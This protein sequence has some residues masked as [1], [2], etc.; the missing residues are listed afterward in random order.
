VLAVVY[1][2]QEITYAELNKKANALA[3]KL[4]SI[5]VGPDDFVPI[6]AQRSAEMLIGLYAVLKAGGAYVPMDPDYPDERIRYMLEDCRPKAI[7]TY[8]AEMDVETDAKVLDLEDEKLYEGSTR[9]LSKVTGPDNLAYCI[10]TSGTT[11]RPKGVMIK[12]R[13][14]VNYVMAKKNTTMTYAYENHLTRFVSVTNMVF[15]IFV[16]EAIAT[17]LTGMTVYVAN[18]EQ[19]NDLAAFERLVADH[20][21]EILQTTPSRIKGLLAQNGN[22]TAFKSMKYVMLGGESVGSDVVK[23]LK[24]V[25]GAVIENVYGPS[26]TTVWST[27]MPIEKEYRNIPVGKPIANTQV[28]V[29]DGGSLCGIGVPGELCIAGDGVARGYLNQSELTAE[30]FVDNPF[31]EGRMYHTGDLAR[32]LPDGNVEYLGRM[33]DQVKVGGFRIE[34]GEIEAKLRE[35]SGVK[36]C[37]VVVREDARGEKVICAY[38]VGENE[39][40]IQEIRN[41]LGKSLPKYM[42]PSYMT[43][44]PQIPVNKNGKLDK[45]ALPEISQESSADYDAPINEQEVVLTDEIKGMLN[46]DT[47]SR[48]D[49]FFEIGGNSMKATILSSH[50]RERGYEISVREIMSL[51]IIADIA[52]RMILNSMEQQQ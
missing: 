14:V 24:E 2:D 35:I 51:G 19:Q 12:N 1:E 10:Y 48:N 16:T 11:G 50:L 32:W 45:K 27:C 46:L 25:T 22:T 42:I 13:N 40:G 17:M 8:K 30:K 52:Q 23:R 39:N 41:E 37:A 38:I 26:E 31:G 9:N 20:Q 44:I 34:L 7:L 3:R 18:R 5:G 21:I 4:R 28:Y 36:D 43:Y 15:D 6:L 29:V 33:D 49:D 47:V